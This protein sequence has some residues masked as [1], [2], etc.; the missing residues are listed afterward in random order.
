[1]KRLLG[2]LV[3][4]LV[5]ITTSAFGQKKETLRHEFDEI[6]RTVYLVISPVH[7][8]TWAIDGEG[9]CTAYPSRVSF[10]G[11]EIKFPRGTVWEISETTDSTMTIDFPKGNSVTYEKTYRSP[12]VICG[13]K[14]DK[15]I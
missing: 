1:M 9:N 6:D 10:E 12:R 2:L 13:V 4:V 14:E 7:L 11:N 15:E 3:L 8:E 5:L